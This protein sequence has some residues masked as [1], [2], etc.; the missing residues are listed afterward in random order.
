MLSGKTIGQYYAALFFMDLSVE[1]ALPSLLVLQAA[2]AA[3][4]SGVCAVAAGLLLAGGV[5]DV[6]VLVSCMI[7][8]L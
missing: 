4:C 7:Y 1:H 6:V 8:S 5:D 2:P 3:F